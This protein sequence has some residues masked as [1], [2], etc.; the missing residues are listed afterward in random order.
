MQLACELEIMD[1]NLVMDQQGAADMPEHDMGVTEFEFGSST[2]VNALNDYNSLQSGSIVKTPEVKVADDKYLSNEAI[3]AAETASLDYAAGKNHVNFEPTI[4]QDFSKSGSQYLTGDGGMQRGEELLAMCGVQEGEWRNYV[5]NGGYV[6]AGY[7][8]ESK[9][10]YA[11]EGRNELYSQYESGVLSYSDFLYRAYGKDL[12]ALDG[13]NVESVSYWYDRLKQGYTES[14]TSNAVYMEDL[15]S[16]AESQFQQDEYMQGL[17]RSKETFA[18]LSN[19]EELTEDTFANYFGAQFTDEYLDALGGYAG[20]MDKYKAGMLN[21]NPF[22]DANGDGKISD[23]DFMFHDDGKIYKLGVGATIKQRDEDGNPIEVVVGDTKNAVAKGFGKF[24]WGVFNGFVGGIADTVITLGALIADGFANI[25]D[26]DH[27]TKFTTEYITKK[28]AWENSWL[29]DDVWTADGAKSTQEQAMQAVDAVGNIT[30]MILMTVATMGIG[31]AASGAQLLAS[32]A[33]DVAV[34]GAKQLSKAGVKLTK[35]GLANALKNSTDDAVI[36][37][38]NTF[39]LEQHV[40]TAGLKAAFNL[41]PKNAIK[42][43]GAGIIKTAATGLGSFTQFSNGV[44][45]GTLP[46]S[47]SI[48]ARAWASSAASAAVLTARDFVDNVGRSFALN[49]AIPDV[50]SRRSAGQIITDAAGVAVINFAISTTLRA[51]WDDVGITGR[52]GSVADGVVTKT[53]AQ[54]GAVARSIAKLYASPSK[55]AALADTLADSAEMVFTNVNNQYVLSGG[56]STLGATE[57]GNIMKNYLSS[58]AGLI[59]L[60]YSSVAT[61]RGSM[62]G[63]GV[64]HRPYQ[65][66]AQSAADVD[67]TLNNALDSIKQGLINK[68]AEVDSQE[69]IKAVDDEIEVFKSAVQDYAKGKTDFGYIYNGPEKFGVAFDKDGLMT[70]TYD[71]ESGAKPGVVSFE[72]KTRA[73]DNDGKYQDAVEHIYYTGNNETRDALKAEGVSDAA[74][75]DITSLP[76]SF[77]IMVNAHRFAQKY[78]A[79]GQLTEAVNKTID[80][81]SVRNRLR[82]SSQVAERLAFY[83][84]TQKQLGDV[85][86][87]GPQKLLDKI[88][89]TAKD[90]AKNIFEAMT[91]KGSPFRGKK[92]A[93]VIG[94]NVDFD[95][96]REYWLDMIE[97]PERMFRSKFSFGNV[98]KS[99][100]EDITAAAKKFLDTESFTETYKKLAEMMSSEEADPEVIKKNHKELGLEENQIDDFFAILDKAKKIYGE[101]EGMTDLQVCRIKNGEALGADWNNEGVQ[102]ELG[103]M[104][105]I[106]KSLHDITNSSS[107]KAKQADSNRD[108]VV[109]KAKLS[110]VDE[111]FVIFR[112]TGDPAQIL[113]SETRFHESFA[114]M[115]S[116]SKASNPVEVLECVDGL[117]STCVIFNPDNVADSVKNRARVAMIDRLLFNE[118]ISIANAA[119]TYK[120]IPG[121]KNLRGRKNL[122]NVV[123]IYDAYLEVIKTF[124]SLRDAFQKKATDDNAYKNALD[125]F[126]NKFK[127]F[128]NMVAGGNN[129]KLEDSPFFKP[130]GFCNPE[131]IELF[132]KAADGTPDFRMSQLINKLDP[133]TV[134][135]LLGSGNDASKISPEDFVKLIFKVTGVEELQNEIKKIIDRTEAKV[136]DIDTFREELSSAIAIAKSHL[137]AKAEYDPHS[138]ESATKVI[139]LIESFEPDKENDSTEDLLNKATKFLDTVHSDHELLNGKQRAE[140]RRKVK[141]Y[142]REAKLA[143]YSKVKEASPEFSKFYKHDE[144]FDEYYPIKN[145]SISYGAFKEML[146]FIKPA[147]SEMDMLVESLKGYE[148]AMANTDIVSKSKLCVINLTEFVPKTELDIRKAVDAARTGAVKTDAPIAEAYKAG[149]GAFKIAVE[150]ARY[151]NLVQFDRNNIPYLVFDTTHSGIR[152]VIDFLEYMGYDKV[153]ASNINDIDGVMYMPHSNRGFRI[154]AEKSLMEKL[155]TEVSK[156]IRSTD[157]TE[158][159]DVTQ[160]IIN[161]ANSNVIVTRDSIVDGGSLE[162]VLGDFI[163][164]GVATKRTISSTVQV[165]QTGIKLGKGG[166][167]TAKSIA[168][169][170]FTSNALSGDTN[171]TLGKHTVALFALTQMFENLKNYVPSSNDENNRG[172]TKTPIKVENKTKRNFLEKFGITFNDND[173]TIATFSMDPFHAAATFYSKLI[174]NNAKVVDMLPVSDSALDKIKDGDFETVNIPGHAVAFV[175]EG[176]SSFS[177]NFSTNLRMSLGTAEQSGDGLDLLKVILSLDKDGSEYCIKSDTGKGGYFYFDHYTKNIGFE[178]DQ[179]HTVGQLIENIDKM[180]KAD[181]SKPVNFY[182]WSIKN[183]LEGLISLGEM[184]AKE[185][186]KF[187]F[188]GDADIRNLIIKRFNEGNANYSKIVEEIRDLKRTNTN[189][190][191]HDVVEKDSNNKMSLNP[192]N[193]VVFKQFGDYA[194]IQG[195]SSTSAKAL[196]IRPSDEVFE[197]LKGKV[198][199]DALRELSENFVLHLNTIGDPSYKISAKEQVDATVGAL[200]LRCESEDE[201][202]SISYNI[203]TDDLIALSKDELNRLINVLGVKGDLK[204][205]IKKTHAALERVMY[206]SLPDFVYEYENTRAFVTPRGPDPSGASD[207]TNRLATDSSYV[208]KTQDYKDQEIV[209]AHRLLRAAK[210]KGQKKIMSLE[211]S[212]AG[213]SV[214]Q[215]A[216]DRYILSQDGVILT[217]AGSRMTYDLT[218]NWQSAKFLFSVKSMMSLVGDVLKQNGIPDIDDEQVMKLSLEALIKTTG[219]Q[220][221]DGYEGTFFILSDNETNEIS[222]K[223]GIRT[224]ETRRDD[225]VDTLK[226]YMEIDADKTKTLHGVLILDKDE[227]VESGNI[228]AISMYGKNDEDRT[229]FETEAGKKFKRDITTQIFYKTSFERRKNESAQDFWNRQV[230]H[231]RLLTAV[232]DS[233]V[234]ELNLPREMA[235]AFVNNAITMSQSVLN[236]DSPLRVEAVVNGLLDKLIGSYDIAGM[237]NSDLKNMIKKKQSIATRAINDVIMFGVSDAN[238]P[239]SIKIAMN[240]RAFDIISMNGL[241][242]ASKAIKSFDNGDENIKYSGTPEGLIKSLI[243]KSTSAAARSLYLKAIAGVDA[244]SIYKTPEYVI[245][246]HFDGYTEDGRFIPGWKE[247]R[248]GE[249]VGFD[250]EWI[251]DNDGNLILTQ[252]SFTIFNGTD[253]AENGFKNTETMTISFPTGLARNQENNDRFSDYRKAMMLKYQKDN[254]G[255]DE[256]KAKQYVDDMMYGPED[257][258]LAKNGS[259]ILATI[260]NGD[261]VTSFGYTG[262]KAEALNAVDQKI[263]EFIGEQKYFIGYN[264]K[265]KGSDY[266]V[267]KAAGLVETLKCITPTAENEVVH[268]D[269]YN[270]LVTKVISSAKTA[271]EKPLA[272]VDQSLATLSRD[273]LGEKVKEIVN[274]DTGSHD[275]E[276][277]ARVLVAVLFKLYGFDDKADNLQGFVGKNPAMAGSQQ[278]ITKNIVDDLLKRCGLEVPA[279]D[280]DRLIRDAYNELKTSFDGDDELRSNRF[281]TNVSGYKGL[282]NESLRKVVD[283]LSSLRRAQDLKVFLKQTRDSLDKLLGSTKDVIDLFDSKSTYDKATKVL[284]YLLGNITPG[285]FNTVLKDFYDAL[286][287]KYGRKGTNVDGEE[288]KFLSRKGSFEALVNLAKSSDA[289]IQSFFNDLTAKKHGFSAPAFAEYSSP[290]YDVAK[291]TFDSFGEANIERE[292]DNVDDNEFSYKIEG[293]LSLADLNGPMSEIVSDNGILS[294][295]NIFSDFLYD[296]S[297]R[298]FYGDHIDKAISETMFTADGL[299]DALK[300]VMLKDIKFRRIVRKATPIDVGAKVN[301]VVFK[302]TLVTS[303]DIVL[304]KRS[305]ELLYGMSYEDACKNYA[306]PGEE[307]SHIYANVLRQPTSSSGS[308]VPVRLIV[309][310]DTKLDGAM[311]MTKILAKHLNGDFD[312]DAPLLFFSNKEQS[313]L[314]KITRDGNLAAFRMLDKA[315][316][317]SRKA[318][319]SQN[320]PEALA[321]DAAEDKLTT[322]TNIAAELFE[323]YISVVVKREGSEFHK[324]YEEARSKVKEALEEKLKYPTNEQIDFVMNNYIMEKVQQGTAEAGLYVYY[325]KNR[326]VLNHDSV[327]KISGAEEVFDKMREAVLNVRLANAYSNRFL[328]SATGQAQRFIFEKQGHDFDIVLDGNPNFRY[329]SIALNE[330]VEAAIRNVFKSEKLK[331]RLLDALEIKMPEGANFGFEDFMGL[332]DATLAENNF[333]AGEELAKPENKSRFSEAIKKDQAEMAIRSAAL[334]YYQQLEAALHLET[335]L[336]KDTPAVYDE[337]AK[338]IVNTYVFDDRDAVQKERQTIPITTF[339]PAKEGPDSVDSVKILDYK[340]KLFKGALTIKFQNNLNIEPGYV[341]KKEETI[342]GVTIPANSTVMASFKDG[343]LIRVSKD[344]F[345]AGTKLVGIHGGAK[346]TTML[347]DGPKSEEE[348]WLMDVVDKSSR[349]KDFIGS[350]ILAYAKKP[351]EKG[352]ETQLDKMQKVTKDGKLVGW[353]VKREYSVTE[354]PGARKTDTAE[355]YIDYYS[356]SANLLSLPSLIQFGGTVVPMKWFLEEDPEKIRINANSIYEIKNHANIARRKMSGAVDGRI[357]YQRAVIYT[358]VDLAIKNKIKGAEEFASAWRSRE[359]SDPDKGPQIVF[360]LLSKF[361]NN[362]LTKV[363]ATEEQKALLSHELF[364]KAFG[365]TESGLNPNTESIALFSKSKQSAQV[366]ANRGQSLSGQDSTT[367]N[368]EVEKTGLLKPSG[369]LPTI[370]WIN[371]MSNAGGRGIITDST[372]I[373]RTQPVQR[374]SSGDPFTMHSGDSK[375]GVPGAVIS[376]V[377]G[378][379][380]NITKDVFSF[381]DDEIDSITRT[382]KAKRGNKYYNKEE[383]LDSMN[384]NRSLRKKSSSKVGKVLA[385]A[386]L[387]HA[388]DNAY[389]TLIDRANY[390]NPDAKTSVSYRDSHTEY[391]P[392]YENGVLTGLVPMTKLDVSE[393]AFTKAKISD[394]KDELTPYGLARGSYKN[395]VFAQTRSE[396][397]MNA[398][399]DSFA[400]ENSNVLSE[401]QARRAKAEASLPE[402]L[403]KVNDDLDAETRSDGELVKYRIIGN[404]TYESTST[405]TKDKL[406][407]LG[408][409][410]DDG[411]TAEALNEIRRIDEILDTPKVIV[412]YE[413]DIRDSKYNH[414]KAQARLLMTLGRANTTI[415]D[416]NNYMTMRGILERLVTDKNYTE[417]EAK[418]SLATTFNKSIDDAKAFVSE[419]DQSKP[420]VVSAAMLMVENLRAVCNSIQGRIPTA[421][422]TWQII[423]TMKATGQ[424][425]V[426]E[427]KSRAKSA[428][429]NLFKSTR[430][431]DFIGSYNATSENGMKDRIAKLTDGNPIDFIGNMSVL[432]DNLYKTQAI[433]RMNSHNIKSNVEILDLLSGMLEES[434]EKKNGDLGERS[435]SRQRAFTLS[436]IARK[437][438]VSIPLTDS[439]ADDFNLAHKKVIEILTQSTA[440]LGLDNKF[441]SEVD[442]M[443]CGSP[444]T[445]FNVSRALLAKEC[446]TLLYKDILVTSPKL[447]TAAVDAIIRGP[448]MSKGKNGSVLVDCYGRKIVP[449]YSNGRY[450]DKSIARPLNDFDLSYIRDAINSNLDSKEDFETTLLV[451]AMTGDIFLMDR[452]LADKLEQHVFTKKIPGRVF[453]AIQKSS[454]WCSKMLMSNPLKIARRFLQFNLWDFNSLM[455]TNPRMILEIPTAKKELSAFMQ[456][457]GAV[458][459]PELEDYLK[460]QGFKYSDIAGYDPVTMESSGGKNSLTD[461]LYFDKVSEV[462]S[463]QNLWMRYAFYRAELDSFNEETKSPVR[464]GSMTYKKDMMDEIKDPGVKAIMVL[465]SKIGGPGGFSELSKELGEKGMV[466]TTFSLAMARWAREGASTAKYVISNI[467][468]Y[469]FGNAV[470]T[471]G[472][473]IAYMGASYGIMYA[474]IMA[475]CDMFDVDE[476]DAKEM[477]AHQE[478]IDPINSLLS[479]GIV[480]VKDNSIWPL[481]SL[482]DSIDSLWEE[483]A[484]EEK[485]VGL[486]NENVISHLPP[487]IK[488]S[489]EALSGKEL[490][491]GKV[492]DND[493]S[494]SDNVE[495]KFLSYIIGASGANALVNTG[496]N[497]SIADKIA[498]ALAAETG[499]SKAYKSDKKAYQ[500]TLSRLNN[501]ISSKYSNDPTIGSN[502]TEEELSEIYSLKKELEEAITSGKGYDVVTK[503]ITDNQSRH[504]YTDAQVRSALRSFSVIGKLEYLRSA[505]LLDDFEQSLSEEDIDR[506]QKAIKFEEAYFPYI[507]DALEDTYDDEQEYTRYKYNNVGGRYYPSRNYSNS[508]GYSKLNW[509]TPAKNKDG[510]DMPNLK[511][512][513]I[514]RVTNTTG[515]KAIDITDLIGEYYDNYYEDNSGTIDGEYYS[516]RKNKKDGQSDWRN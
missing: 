481:Q 167:A 291:A 397:G 283:G 3:K 124:D 159:L 14:I 371:E 429:N 403:K 12:M 97:H 327:K 5:K 195:V 53:G 287:D 474:M 22:I 128:E 353:L 209:T 338:S 190:S 329:K 282:S 72:K 36:A 273:L 280:I 218:N 303:A 2:G 324:A 277:D 476:E 461:R 7:E 166:N 125:N 260:K 183:T 462:F 420:E 213:D 56:F 495:R 372:A 345:H 86:K 392:I 73:R 27:G 81:L 234:T 114:A 57:Y 156:E 455:S 204:N 13:H 85:A 9:L 508:K 174:K 194:E 426:E 216:W 66:L 235:S 181:K 454:R 288:S 84:H 74:I 272:Q 31:T 106:F 50:E 443:A 269:A 298:L 433:I 96:D 217:N 224:T 230:P 130:G 58:P 254:P 396:L 375:A 331:K 107:T 261:K 161:L 104:Q 182:L 513:F 395:S 464:Y 20:V 362:D 449:E 147:K 383:E 466:F 55:L 63:T 506:L 163:S 199:E 381:D 76:A 105:A 313:H 121:E 359:A 127:E 363:K 356:T 120:I 490:Y 333:K 497:A 180:L 469:G 110:G 132:K 511:D 346:F 119:R 483:D 301:D 113:Q 82:R 29:N 191:N 264:S 33:D 145:P 65:Q 179:E 456:S 379:D 510:I 244:G 249:F 439:A 94:E 285:N 484:L 258:A 89:E 390:I 247:I 275:A 463:F 21:I 242:E 417:A 238:I 99:N 323:K 42:Y 61:Y 155:D 501:L 157:G 193:S 24:V 240:G 407:A 172:T 310:D 432:A 350:D 317:I 389:E 424:G 437:L 336:N 502:Y 160:A 441:A 355:S 293:F 374:P 210:K 452:V 49:D 475:I 444:E 146:A 270:D 226:T 489:F 451:R 153:S 446:L 154:K 93:S 366:M 486:L 500:K 109:V 491:G 299:R 279:E 102:E 69:K 227:G 354:D 382:A 186:N 386:K 428:I 192:S 334:S 248:K 144:D 108:F 233:M 75:R 257:N 361:F 384:P 177:E 297:Q 440:A 59:S 427:N 23:G 123:K 388:D 267:I 171:T 471:L 184:V 404:K 494:L 276:Y 418:S 26:S 151:Q 292:I 339:Y 229:F 322:L 143:L 341:F 150:D 378:F 349:L 470:R 256:S 220:N 62:G 115:Y 10:L 236:G 225:I 367:V 448:L 198:T 196:G 41:G 416:L 169:R 4:E 493:Y 92:W 358:L 305:F 352:K 241:E 138:R 158:N 380:P 251:Y 504:G 149:G 237:D 28:D 516:G 103:K 231:A 252:L 165:D 415:D 117:I 430:V 393:D 51:T 438:G 409:R 512:L 503:I 126:R 266:D 71:K 342:G 472:T 405:V 259:T 399:Y 137:N 434:V 253:V 406:Y 206:K 100:I 295:A 421:L 164:N 111:Y 330:E 315:L 507:D 300:E 134:G 412:E 442:I 473:P 52:I 357:A 148:A 223:T 6:P 139:K 373:R 320:T 45:K 255:A 423:L 176:E 40:G 398:D 112:P 219:V 48:G 80:N 79:S 307:Q 203:T 245:S 318:K 215:R 478:F 431:N 64:V 268:L 54:S 306:L 90:R 205:K 168:K 239:D 368:K 457:K 482:I 67:R 304:S 387:L 325:T 414:S 38:I 19:G 17:F 188:L 243:L 208:R 480:T 505:G 201:D 485:V 410:P 445:D 274:C 337:I 321:I 98:Y 271:D 290:F 467:D 200:L 11:A 487:A 450:T 477:A 263:K 175:S 278:E 340:G 312:G 250:C 347:D 316:E 400:R 221:S 246:K 425:S 39:G 185:D 44:V 173:N 369:Y 197:A 78:G 411:A 187:S 308:F 515:S 436:E 289:E 435:R 43:L 101:S 360:S 47:L 162:F 15:L 34:Q 479:G 370:E 135:L 458:R 294:E 262:G 265:G 170:I 402:I 488:S 32:G 413:N 118:G 30:G 302:E 222:F 408:M 343:M 514:N 136:S 377:Y 133:D 178:L 314:L 60:T 492:I 460:H 465:D 35:S 468:D 88:K 16:R 207:S 391:F 212:I 344:S 509:Y 91:G 77:H 385:M 498:T 401:V 83:A 95:V 129:I 499:N 232:V 453:Q 348:S 25:G 37:A 8:M 459:T 140:V 286:V 326:D 1:E 419:F 335:V 328:P 122:S 447:R 214:I 46:H 189:N 284:S 496:S 18:N 68:K 70:T 211:T 202:G 87:E 422:D 376:T 364:S 365:F 141:G 311:G 351:L 296:T 152:D 142:L 332:M 281:I 131:L 228:R 319:A 309:V 394:F 116:L